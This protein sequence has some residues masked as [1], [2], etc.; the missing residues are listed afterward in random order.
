MVQTIW[1]DD[2]E[3]HVIEDVRQYGWH[4]VLIEDA[5]E[6]PAFAYSIGIWHTLKQPEIIIFGLGNTKTMGNIIN[7]V[8]EEMRKGTKFEDWME[9]DQILDGYNCI[10]RQVDPAFYPDYV[11]YAM[12]FHRPDDFPVL[13]CVW[14]DREGRYPWHPEFSA[15]LHARQPVLARQHPWRFQEGK[16]RAVFTTKHVLDGT[17]PILLV[18]HD[19]EGDWQFLCG[20][21]NRPEDGRIVCLANVVEQHPAVME[22]A[23]LPRG[24]QAVRDGVNRPWR[25]VT[26]PPQE[27]N[28][29]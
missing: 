6:G 14:P 25:R 10:F 18:S 22:L 24:W 17:R 1:H 3:R 2:D 11:G 26:S 29:Q 21:T 27:E 9:S 16:N 13:Q 28:Q 5:P 23:D 15:E 7:V 8:G 4:I 20:T 19:E 12:W